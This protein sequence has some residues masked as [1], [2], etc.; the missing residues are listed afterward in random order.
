M[1]VGHPVRRRAAGIDHA[2]GALIGLYWKVIG[3][4]LLFAAAIGAIWSV[5]RRWSPA[6]TACRWPV[7]QAAG[8]VQSVPLLVLAGIGYLATV[9][10]ST[11]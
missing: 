1:A 5:A 11:W 3:W 6:C 10:G 4:F 8:L 9:L 2:R 7:L